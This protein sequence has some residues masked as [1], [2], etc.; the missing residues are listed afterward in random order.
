MSELIQFPKG[1]VKGI[2]SKIISFTAQTPEIIDLMSMGLSEEELHLRPAP[3]QWC[4]VELVCHL[5]DV[6]M[7]ALRKRIQAMMEKDRNPIPAID[8]D[9]LAEKNRY[10]KRSFAEAMAGFRDIR[11]E[12][13]TTI[14]EVNPEDW[15]R[16]GLHPRFGEVSLGSWIVAWFFHDSSH[17][18]QLLNRRMHLLR[19]WVG[20]Y[21]AGYTDDLRL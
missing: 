15:N 20:G 18:R 10:I 7:L 11:R 16:V 19:E 6:D 5:T 21:E 8:P 12:S 9:S 2:R 4:M 13:L 17:M 1:K 14:Q 3:D